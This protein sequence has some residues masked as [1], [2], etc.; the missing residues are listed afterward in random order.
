MFKDIS[1]I[2]T[3]FFRPGVVLRP[4]LCFQEVSVRENNLNVSRVKELFADRNLVDAR[5]V[6]KKI[7]CKQGK[8]V[9]K[10]PRGSAK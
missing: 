10:T 5:L 9:K 2:H 3:E 1:V 4:G 8:T 7:V 6:L